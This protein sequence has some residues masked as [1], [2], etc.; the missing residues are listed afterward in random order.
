MIIDLK[1]V[2]IAGILL[3]II[4][5]GIFGISRLYVLNHNNKGVQEVVVKSADLTSDVLNSDMADEEAISQE[6]KNNFFAEYRLERERMRSRQMEMLK[7]I[8]NN[9]K[10][11]K[12][13]REAASLRMVEITREM[14]KEL[15]AENLVKSKGI[16][17][18]IV[19]LQSGGGT[20]VVE[21]DN[22]SKEEEAEIRRAVGSV[23]G[24]DYARIFIIVK[25]GDA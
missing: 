18:C 19:L 11:E 2:K 14:E 25:N 3:I 17:D 6:K 24:S 4:L 23:V 9:E 12:K 20:V 22:L 15:K 1:R 16:E 13:A 8:I 21:K 10:A 5:S 7:D